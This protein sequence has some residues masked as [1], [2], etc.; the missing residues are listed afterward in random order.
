GPLRPRSA[1][2]KGGPIP[3]PG[4]GRGRRRDRRRREPARR[5]G[6]RVAYPQVVH[7]LRGRALLLGIGC[8]EMRLS[9]ATRVFLGFAAVLVM[10]GAVSLFGIVQ[11]HRIGQGLSL[12]SSGYF[13]LTRIAAS[14]EGFQ[15]Q[16]ERSTDGLLAE[17]DPAQRASLVRLDRTYFARIAEEHLARAREQL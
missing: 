9:I 16:R 15:R 3:A 10:S 12:V 4:P 11:M 5:E 6:A 2:R 17:R 1:R 7:D 13:P 8:G 14:L